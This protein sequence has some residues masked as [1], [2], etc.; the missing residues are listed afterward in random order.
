MT[1]TLTIKVNSDEKNLILAHKALLKSA[2][3]A[4]YMLNL[5]HF[6]RH[7][8]TKDYPTSEG[9]KSLTMRF[10]DEDFFKYVNEMRIKSRKTWR[11]FIL[12]AVHGDG[13]PDIMK[14]F[15]RQS[16]IMLNVD[17]ANVDWVIK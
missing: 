2:D 5:C 15:D 7:K 13:V 12:E 1:N 17:W 3:W 4:E 8:D 9:A 6:P 11:T 16:K 10:N 14:G